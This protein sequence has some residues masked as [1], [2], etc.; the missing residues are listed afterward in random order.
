MMH[1]IGVYRHVALLWVFILSFDAYVLF[2]LWTSRAQTEQQ[3]LQLAISYVRLAEE[4][5]S[6]SFDRTSILLGQA[7]ILLRPEEL[8]HPES[9]TAERR[10]II[11][12][13][14]ASLQADGRGIV[15]VAMTDA[16]GLVF[17]NSVGA[18]PGNSLADREY[19]QTL[20]RQ[21][22]AAPVISRAVKGRVSNKW[23][24]QVARSLRGPKGEF[25]GMVVANMGLSEYFLPFYQ[26]LLLAPGSV[27]S[28]RDMDHRLVVRYPNVEQAMDRALPAEPVD[29]AF[30]AGQAE[31]TY[32]RVSPV[33]GV[34]RSIAFLKLPH[35]PLYAVVGLAD[36]DTF[37]NWQMGLNRAVLFVVLI[38]VGGGLASAVLRRKQLLERE[39]LVNGDKLA[40]ALKAA[41]A[42]TW[43]WDPPSNRLEWSPELVELYRAARPVSTL[44]DWLACLHP[45][46]RDR[47]HDVLG[48]TVA[49][50]DTAYR[51]EYRVPGGDAAGRDRWLASIGSISYDRDGRPVRA[52][53]VT[54]DITAA[55]RAEAMLQVA[56]DEALEAKTEAERASLSR[57]KFL[58][59]ASHDLRQPVQS[60]LLLIEVLKLRL[61]GTPM[62][63]VTGLME[64]ALDGLRLLLDSLLDISK[65][66][67]GFIAP[68]LAEVELGPLLD[69][70]AEEYR[71]RAAQRGLELRVVPTS[72]RLMSDATLLERV[73]RN[74]LENA[75][76]Y[77][78]SGK[79]LLGCRR[80]AAIVRVE[81]LDTGIG[82][83][84]EHHE[85]VFEEFHQVGNTAR[86]RSQGLGLGLA[87]VRRL[88]GLLGGTIHVHSALNKGARFIFAVP[89][90]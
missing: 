52:V 39:V 61:S 2:D 75:L 5:A 32:R 37:A 70:L 47:A 72:L 17:A 20:R 57:S 66:D 82:I 8:R 42:G 54:I 86:D 71:V 63:Q 69:R 19:F 18:P 45:D 44:N 29:I 73:L 6:A 9:L 49:R 64:T 62:Q 12:A 77:T 46:D 43:Y 59:A 22:S 3:A 4:Q 65:L 16:T 88:A 7:V 10:R 84:P 21:N 25:A 81:V 1:G 24:I 33:D 15:S 68:A 74:L 56:R 28:L 27:I 14:L 51:S 26:S 48:Q 30:F 23:G 35:Y 34:E 53:G 60:L 85:A 79:I 89:K 80:G 83:A 13:G 58:A 55:K 11:E 90:S 38:T 40:L 41:H 76:R 50:G 67:G 31:G 36:R 87:I 78:P